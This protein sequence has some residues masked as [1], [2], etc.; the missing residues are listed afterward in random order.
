MSLGQ[1]EIFSSRDENGGE[2][3]RG[4]RGGVDPPRRADVDG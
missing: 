2:E 1:I 3:G 4:E